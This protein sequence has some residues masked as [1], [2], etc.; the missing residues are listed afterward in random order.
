M[1]TTNNKYGSS[2]SWS[3]NKVNVIANNGVFN[4]P[5]Y[6]TLVTLTATITFADI[7]AT[8]EYTFDVSGQYKGLSN[9]IIA[10]YLYTNISSTSNY[11][12]ENA[13]L[14]FVAFGQAGTN[15]TISNASTIGNSITNY[16]ITKAHNN[17]VQVLLSING[18]DNLSTIAASSS[19]RTIFANNIVSFI[20]TYNINGVDIDWEFPASS[21]GGN[22]T[23]LMKEIKEKVKA[24]N[25]HHLVTA[26][27]GI[28]TYNRYDFANSVQYL[29]YIGVMTYDMNHTEIAQHH[30]ALYYKSG[31]SYK[32]VNNAATYYIVNSGIPASKLIL[33]VPFY[34]KKYINANG[35]G[36][37]ANFNS[38]I[39]FASIKS[40]YL[41]NLS[42][43]VQRYWDDVCKVP[44]IYDS[45]NK[46]FISY[47][48]EQSISL[49][50]QYLKTNGWA[51][52]F[53]W[54]DGQDSGDILFKAMVDNMNL[55]S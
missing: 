42:A 53:S 34:G 49:K 22:F 23:L 51:G 30:S 28:D 39:T 44:Y 52:I 12:F 55:Y 14:L 24:N 21:E 25:P 35:L 17:G 54:Q 27:T 8:R 46:I 18:A 7:T 19:L 33:G 9:G 32:A 47:E 43:T 11:T 3:S 37:A 13:N 48:D 20:N 29:D 10:E 31:S 4:K 26:A 50:V 36:Q 1:P 2:I 5:Y 45:V 41:N 40:D 38:S 16:V 6:P 15:G